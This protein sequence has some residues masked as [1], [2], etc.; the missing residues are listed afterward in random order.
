M[1][2][3]NSGHRPCWHDRQQ[4]I[5]VRVTSGG[6]GYVGFDLPGRRSPAPEAARCLLRRALGGQDTDDLVLCADPSWSAT[7]SCTRRSGLPGGRFLVAVQVEGGGVVL[8][9]VLDEGARTDQDP[10]AARLPGASTDA[11]LTSSAGSRSS[12]DRP[13]VPGP[14]RLVPDQG[15]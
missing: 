10:P 15:L 13:G 7:R 12:P 1:N 14:A 8:V 6:A 3:Q 5:K 9:S 2:A 4:P 11:G